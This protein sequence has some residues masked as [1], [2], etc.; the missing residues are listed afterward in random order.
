[1]MFLT[2]KILKGVL[3]FV[4][5]KILE[6]FLSESQHIFDYV[7]KPNELDIAVKKMKK[8]IKKLK[9]DSH[10]RRKF[11]VCEECKHNIKER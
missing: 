8:D 1:M 4:A 6:M 3:K 2:D 10:P 5:P 11:V 7:D 9:K